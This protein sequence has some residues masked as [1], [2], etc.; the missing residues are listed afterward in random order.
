M[1]ATALRDWKAWPGSSHAASDETGALL[2]G[3][4]DGFVD[5]GSAAWTLRSGNAI[6]DNIEQCGWARWTRAEWLSRPKLLDATAR[7]LAERSRARGIPL[8]KLSGLDVKAGKSGVIGHVDWTVGMKDGSHTDPGPNYPWDVV[9]SRAN[10]LASNSP[11]SPITTLP[12]QEDDDMPY[13]LD[14]IAKAVWEYA[15]VGRPFGDQ[16]GAKMLDLIDQ[17]GSKILTAIDEIPADV[18]AKPVPRPDGQPPMPSG[19]LLGWADR[20]ASLAAVRSADPAAIAAALLPG[21]TAALPQHGN[22]D[23]G[24]IETALRNVLRTGTEA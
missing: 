19:E 11:G 8:V 20:A 9:L 12:V 14:Q 2:S 13:T 6:S 21:L 4:K 7:W 1:R 16:S 18:W 24:V 3:A 23:Q 5:Y 22:V 15:A 17:T 10:A